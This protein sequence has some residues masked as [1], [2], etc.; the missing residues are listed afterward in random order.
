MSTEN[1]H[2]G[3]RILCQ[4]ENEIPGLPDKSVNSF[5]K[6]SSMCGRCVAK[7]GHLSPPLVPW[8]P[9]LPREQCPNVP[10]LVCSTDPRVPAWQELRPVRPQGILIS[11]T[12]Y[13]D[14]AYSCDVMKTDDPVPSLQCFG[15]GENYSLHPGG[16]LRGPP[17]LAPVLHLVFTSLAVFFFFPSLGLSAHPCPST[18][19]SHPTTGIWCSGWEAA[20]PG[21]DHQGCRP[22]CWDE[23]GEDLLQILAA[24]WKALPLGLTTAR[25]MI[26]PYATAHL[27]LLLP[28]GSLSLV[29]HP[30]PFLPPQMPT[31]TCVFSSGLQPPASR[32]PAQFAANTSHLRHGGD[33]RRAAPL[34]NPVCE[35]KAL[36]QDL[37][38][39]N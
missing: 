5:K 18:L 14:R 33:L 30:L 26:Q 34:G 10:A 13:P 32:P 31:C 25:V 8:E 23:L 9:V 4:G 20:E 38:N 11:F 36:S 16:M 15:E 35:P 28:L 22:H 12:V 2:P 24:W 1:R 27:S 17:C 39:I 7:T 6:S 21:P 29:P 37:S 19:L 3:I